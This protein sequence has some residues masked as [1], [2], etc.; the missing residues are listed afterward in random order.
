MKAIMLF[1]LRIRDN[2]ELIIYQ[3]I[4]LKIDRSVNI[5]DVKIYI[6]YMFLKVID[7]CDHAIFSGD[8]D[9][10]FYLEK[11]NLDDNYF[12]TR[13]HLHLSAS[14][15][16]DDMPLW[17]GEVKILRK[18]QEGDEKF[19]LRHGRLD[20]LDFTFC[21]LGQSL[22][23]YNR[24]AR[25]DK[26]L[27]YNIL[28][29]LRDIVIFPEMKDGFEDEEGLEASLYNFLE[30]E[31]DLFS[32]AP[33]M[34]SGDYSNVIDSDVEFK[35]QMNK[36]KVPVKFSFNV[37]DHKYGDPEEQQARIHVITGNEDSGKDKFLSK[38]AKIA[39]AANYDR[40]L[41]KNEGTLDPLNI[42]FARIVCLSYSPAIVFRVPALYVHEKEQIVLEIQ[43]GVG[44]FIYCG[45][46]E[47][48]KELDES[49]KSLTIDE[50]GRVWDHD[51][52]PDEHTHFKTNE[53]L[54]AE[55][56][57]A[58]EAIEQDLEK[59]DLLDDM[60]GFMKEV[61]GLQ[62]I[63]NVEFPRLRDEELQEFF[64]HLAGES[65]ILLHATLHLILGVSPR[66]LVL[67]NAPETYLRPTLVGFLLRFTSHL[68]ERQS[69]TMI[70]ATEST[71]ILRETKSRNVTIFRK[72]GDAIE[73]SVPEIE[74]YGETTE[75]ITQ[76]LNEI[77]QKN[78]S[79]SDTSHTDPETLKNFLHDS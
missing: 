74:T 4:P 2:N 51:A 42:G 14:L 47:L 33:A 31:D 12:M 45:N 25:L 71:E 32:L 39:Y 41:L 21:S 52:P 61:P 73:H 43:K 76:Y 66:S 27:R 77:Q 70:V 40:E 57:K 24:L 50:D 28:S 38:L 55:F 37:P 35:F 53:E 10:A 1:I 11:D 62:F 6:Y 60:F 63:T 78:N 44:R 13:Y 65:Q 54:T 69:A 67:F 79:G 23:Y 58:M 5:V 15:T 36:M 64:Q 19:Q 7:W 3:E 34:I 75:A 18:G 26:E 59:Q 46:H 9:S 56:I 49:L 68:L 20:Y 16:D 8:A 17:I 30:P 29:A 48:A 72:T 22:D